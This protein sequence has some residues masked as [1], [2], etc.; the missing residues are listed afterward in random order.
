M[1]TFQF[2]ILWYGDKCGVGEGM[3]STEHIQYLQ[4]LLF[5]QCLYTKFWYVLLSWNYVC[6]GYFCSLVLI[7]CL[8]RIVSLIIANIDVIIAVLM[9][10]SFS[11][12]KTGLS[13][14]MTLT[15]VSCSLVSVKG[16]FSLPLWKNVVFLFTCAW[17]QLDFWFLLFT[18]WSVQMF[19][20]FVQQWNCDSFFF[21]HA[22]SQLGLCHL[23]STVRSFI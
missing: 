10:V 11:F 18:V 4:Y 14:T 13:I 7:T 22:W 6:F 17:V 12:L 19:S 8:T 16:F 3:C 2:P 23:L 15:S 1:F 21:S 5:V 9:R 20:F